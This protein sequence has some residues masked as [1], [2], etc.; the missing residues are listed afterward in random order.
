MLL[1][2]SSQRLDFPIYEFVS[3]SLKREHPGLGPCVS[4]PCISRTLY[5]RAGTQQGLRTEMKELSE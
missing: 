4:L 2:R 1:W 3:P 5:A